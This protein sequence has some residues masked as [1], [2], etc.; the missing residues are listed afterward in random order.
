M[1]I[2][3]NAGHTITGKGYGAVG[4]IKE[5]EHT[6]L[7]ADELIRL[8]G[9]KAIDL[10]VDTSRSYLTDVVKKANESKCDLLVSIHF[11]A[12]KGVG[13]EAYTWCGNKVK[14]A[15]KICEEL[16]NNSEVRCC[17]LRELLRHGYQ[18]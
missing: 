5:S 13:C 14:E 2:G 6:R 18:K 10:T 4:L 7:V 17:F 9:D 8:L 11:N 3:V 16:N 15:V 1:K 12:G